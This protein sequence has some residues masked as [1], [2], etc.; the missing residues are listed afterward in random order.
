MMVGSKGFGGEKVSD[1]RSAVDVCGGFD[2]SH[3]CGDRTLCETETSAADERCTR[4]TV[5]HRRRNS[6]KSDGAPKAEEPK[7]FGAAMLYLAGI[8]IISPFLELAD[9]LHGLIGLVILF[10]GVN[11]A[12]KIA[13]GNPQLDV[14]GPYENT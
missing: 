6:P 4:G 14:S 9:P 8:G 1:R 2:G 12:W 3:S 11:I 10:V 5:D 13:R 7:S